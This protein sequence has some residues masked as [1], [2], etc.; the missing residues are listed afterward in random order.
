ML[1]A[2]RGC[3]A[4]LCVHLLTSVWNGLLWHGNIF[5]QRSPAITICAHL[6]LLQLHVK[7]RLLNSLNIKYDSHFDSFSVPI[8]IGVTLKPLSLFCERDKPIFYFLTSFSSITGTTGGKLNLWSLIEK[9]PPTWVS[10]LGFIS[11]TL[12]G[13][14]TLFEPLVFDPHFFPP[15]DPSHPSFTDSHSPPPTLPYPIIDR[16]AYI[17]GLV[18]VSGSTSYKVLLSDYSHK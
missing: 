3:C 6:G 2:A 16:F 15:L 8:Y 4:H 9:L 13:L 10:H 12:P 1:T 18:F 5:L 14:C 17:S 11:P 7:G